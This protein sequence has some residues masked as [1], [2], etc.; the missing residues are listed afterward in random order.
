MDV[1]FPYFPNFYS[2]VF[3]VSYFKNYINSFLEF[4]LLILINYVLMSHPILHVK[5]RSCQ[6]NEKNTAYI[7]MQ[8]LITL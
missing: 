6:L 8:G 7:T 1:F 3:H 4:F 2:I 5:W